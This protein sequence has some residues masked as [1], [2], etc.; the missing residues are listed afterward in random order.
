MLLSAP[1]G[2]GPL[3]IVCD[4]SNRGIGCAL[5]QMQQGDP[6][7]LEFCSNKLTVA[8][9]KWDTREREAFAIKW[10]LER[11]FDFTELSPSSW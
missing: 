2:D 9:Q 8:E 10:S 3:V 1:R 5:L 6:V 7:L 11:F 4:A